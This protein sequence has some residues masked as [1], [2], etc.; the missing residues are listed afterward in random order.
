MRR[1]RS[2]PVLL[3]LLAALT[4]PAGQ[5]SPAAASTPQPV[6]VLMYHVIA[7]PPASAPYPEL[8]VRPA[9][10]AAQMTWLE[11]R[12]YR[13]VTLRAVWD[14]WHGDGVLP[15]RPVVITFDD[16]YLSVGQRAL[17]ELRARGWA[18]VLNLTVRHL[19]QELR[20]AW[21]RKLIAAG[22]E[23]DSHTITH[24]DLRSLD[25]RRLR[26]EVQG[27]RAILRRRFGVPVDFF[28]YP[29]GRY[30]ARVVASVRAAGYLGATTT[31][32]G[33]ARADEPFTLDRVR[34]NRSDGAAG[35]AAKLR[36]R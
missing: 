11:R 6:P 30:D 5:G 27:S 33:L 28:C 29:S 12:G 20:P 36:A 8:F 18:G 1:S 26:A 13:A 19:D 32:E 15:A 7:D 35:L 24:P 23:I 3:S 4:W 9:D 10:F 31:E 14:A 2:H 22:W 25:D 17:P 16:G 34:V 21:I